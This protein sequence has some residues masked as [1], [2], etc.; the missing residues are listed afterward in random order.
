VCLVFAK[1]KELWL[2]KPKPQIAITMKREIFM[3]YSPVVKTTF[4]AKTTSRH[5]TFILAVN[6]FK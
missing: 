2:S 5:L 1:E 3:I 6:K 4:L